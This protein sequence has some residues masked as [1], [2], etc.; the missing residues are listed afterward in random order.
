M[1]HDGDGRAVTSVHLADEALSVSGGSFHAFV[2]GDVERGHVVDPTSG[3]PVEAGR[4]AWVRHAQA[5]GA[6]ALST[7]LLVRGRVLPGIGG[8]RGGW[9]D[10]PADRPVDWPATGP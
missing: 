3:V 2:D 4:L 10:D 6:D 8:A 9:V 1:I 7:A 5:A